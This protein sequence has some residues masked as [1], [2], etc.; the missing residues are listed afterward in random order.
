MECAGDEMSE[1]GGTETWL[2]MV[3]RGGLWHVNDQT[4]GLFVSMEE[5]ARQYFCTSERATAIKIIQDSIL[6]S[7]DLLFQWSLISA[8]SDDDVAS[9]V[10]F[11]IVKLYTTIRGFAFAKTCM[12]QY[13]QAKRKTTQKSRALRSNLFVDH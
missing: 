10:L 2:N 1:D 8:D 7:N 12:E 9:T 13:K 3:D 6:K 11:E 5:L 4:Y